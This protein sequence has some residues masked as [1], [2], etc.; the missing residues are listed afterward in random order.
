MRERKAVVAGHICLDITPVFPEKRGDNLKTGEERQEKVENL[1]KPGNLVNVGTA[2]VNTGG[3]VANTGLAM[4]KMGITVCLMGK[5]GEDE[6]GR[7]IRSI[8]KEYGSEQGL[9]TDPASS[10][11]YSIVLA[12]P[13]I[14]RI[15]L[16]NPGA[17]HTFSYSDISW[18][19][20]EEADLFHFGY[21]PLMKQ[22][23][24]DQGKELSKVFQKAD[25]TGAITS[26]D[27]AAVEPDSE[28]GRENWEEILKNVLPYVDFFVPSFEEL[29]FMID[30]ERYEKLVKAA[31]TREIT[32]VMSLEN[33][34]KPLAKKAK[35]LGAKSILIKCG[36]PGIYYKMGN[37][38]ELK[39]AGQRLGQSMEDWADREGFEKSY[40][41]AA[42]LS[43]TGAGDTTIA[44]F[45]SAMLKGRSLEMCLKVAAATGASCVEAYDALGGILTVE[46]QEKRIEQGL[47]KQD[48][49]R[50]GTLWEEN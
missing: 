38:N 17:N 14:D 42:V 24:K 22:M 39:K 16:H 23:Y 26:L 44:G 19:K 7:I 13:G 18:E 25:E 5:T 40:E 48:F 46:E 15:F 35:E 4:K 37:V 2:Q 29:C 8:L 30:R 21:P 10:T 34:V 47:K 50:G 31:G 11:S 32:E 12:M 6:F 41:P 20:V 9:I 43:G 36:A 45:L 3:V 49:K 27:L 33:D 1:L 28:P